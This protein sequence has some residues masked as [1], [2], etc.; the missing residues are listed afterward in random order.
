LAM[1]LISTG[2]TGTFRTLQRSK[3]P[4]EQNCWET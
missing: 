3:A 2:S 4:N 1:G